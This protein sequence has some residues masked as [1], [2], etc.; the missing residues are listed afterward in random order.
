M[1]PAC[2][3]T[4]VEV[5]PPSHTQCRPD[6]L[7]QRTQTDPQH[8]I[9]ADL[10]VYFLPR[11]SRFRLYFP[12]A[13]RGFAFFHKQTLIAGRRGSGCDDQVRVGS[14]IYFIETMSGSPFG[15]AL[16]PLGAMLLERCEPGTMLYAVPEPVQDAV[17]ASL[18]KRLSR[19]PTFPHDFR[20]LVRTRKTAAD[21]SPRL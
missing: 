11:G 9:G 6:G 16:R 17:V 13:L 1:K 15:A 12:P 14:S 18:L 4:I 8:P 20:P 10:L 7:T 3:L 2:E 5:V 21:L 19:R